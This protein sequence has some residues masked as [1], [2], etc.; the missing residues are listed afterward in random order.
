M[1]TYLLK[2]NGVKDAGKLK[3]QEKIEMCRKYDCYEKTLKEI[4]NGILYKD[5]YRIDIEEFLKGNIKIIEQEEK[6]IE[7]EYFDITK[8]DI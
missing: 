3:L 7:D 1:I 6:K 5:G 4:E 2:R 8:W